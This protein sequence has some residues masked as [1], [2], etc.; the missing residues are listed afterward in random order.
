MATLVAALMDCSLRAI[1][2]RNSANVVAPRQ[3]S[4]GGD[5]R[6]EIKIIFRQ[7]PPDDDDFQLIN[8]PTKK[9]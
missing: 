8:N 1:T 3:R 6:I 2:I 5:V 7:S 9:S 4:S